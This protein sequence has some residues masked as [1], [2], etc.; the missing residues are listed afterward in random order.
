MD[1]QYPE[2]TIAQTIVA[3]MRA[4][5]LLGSGNSPD[6]A[7][8]AAEA[9]AAVAPYELNSELYLLPIY[10]RG[11]AYL[12]SGKSTEARIEFQKIIDH[13]GITRN[14]ITGAL[15]HLGLARAWALAGDKIKARAAY[16]DFFT[17]WKDADPDVPVL[18]DARKS[19]AALGQ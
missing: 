13:P 5:L 19:F 8:R 7:R 6:G 15:A 10:V 4:G 14:F 12:A 17:L 11:Q 2:D 18:V 9:L 16:Q 1:K 3:T